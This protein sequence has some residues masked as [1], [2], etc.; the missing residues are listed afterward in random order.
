MALRGGCPTRPALA[1]ARRRVRPL[2]A[3]VCAFVADASVADAR[4]AV[5][6]TRDLYASTPAVE[7]AVAILC[8]SPPES[9]VVASGLWDGTWEVVHAPH[10][11]S[12]DA[13]GVRFTPVRYV[14]SGTGSCCRSDVH[15]NF[16]GASGWL[17]AAGTLH[18]SGVAVELLFTEFW[19]SGECEEARPFPTGSEATLLDHCIQAVGRLGFV[20]S[21]SVFPVAFLDEGITIFSFPPLRTLICAKKRSG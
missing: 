6:S 9:S 17:S 13:L 11:R 1:T 19:V 14:V 21:L 15:W 10:L 16:L 3:S 4:A 8:N 18:A 2:A 5:L 20:P 7:E 12:V